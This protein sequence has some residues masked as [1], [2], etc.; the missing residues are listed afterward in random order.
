MSTTASAEALSLLETLTVQSLNLGETSTTTN[1]AELSEVGDDFVLASKIMIVDDEAYNIQVFHKHLQLAGYRYFC[2][3]SDSTQAMTMLRREKPDLLLLDI[4]MPEVS[5]L[6]IL[7]ELRST[8]EYRHLPVIVLTAS[9]SRETK[10]RALQLGTNDYLHKPI[11]YEDLTLRVRNVL[12]M[13]AFQDRLR[14][15]AERLE[16]IVQ[17]RTAE[18]AAS[19]EEII[20]CLARAGEFRDNETGNHVVRVGKYTGVIARELGFSPERVEI[21]EQAAQLHDL[22]KIAIPD[23]ILLNPGKLS[24]DEFDFMKKHCLF[25]RDIIQP[26]SVE[27]RD[28]LQRHSMLGAQLLS[29]RGTPVLATAALIALTHHE[30]W[31]GSGYPLGLA[32]EDIPLEGRMTAVADV[33]D[34]LSTKRPYKPAFPRQK[35]FDILEAERGKHF[36]PRVLDAFFRRQDEVVQIQIDYAS[37]E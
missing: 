26:L 5:G 23:S 10:Q 14:R 9:T 34:A 37:N 19:R 30:K 3:T 21:L 35:C 4:M 17:R 7:Q 29:V 8:P 36:D 25:G 6:D 15:H 27:A 22:G 33:F 32:G 12:L 20:R 13:K 24:P 1:V 16:E 18:L 2:T 11:D 28:R 31:D